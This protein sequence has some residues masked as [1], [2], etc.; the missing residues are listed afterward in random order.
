VHS[1]FFAYRCLLDAYNN[2]TSSSGGSTSALVL[3][4]EE[5]TKSLHR[6]I[7]NYKDDILKHTVFYNFKITLNWAAAAQNPRTSSSSSSSSPSPSPSVVSQPVLTNDDTAHV[8][9][10]VFIRIT[11]LLRDRM[12]ALRLPALS[13]CLRVYTDSSD[14]TMYTLQPSKHAT[15]M[16]SLHV[17]LLIDNS[18]NDKR[19]ILD[20]TLGVYG[21]LTP[22][23]FIRI[24][25]GIIDAFT[26]AVKFQGSMLY[27]AYTTVDVNPICC[28]AELTHVFTDL[29]M[30]ETSL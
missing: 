20:I 28:I 29:T 15:V 1:L 18:N 14:D 13:T 16:Q 12:S 9:T 5:S 26:I 27:G 17:N 30:L 25:G 11:E 21:W 23:N 6:R 7:L 3:S 2:K 19:T 10:S 8:V 24:D 4:L 22:P